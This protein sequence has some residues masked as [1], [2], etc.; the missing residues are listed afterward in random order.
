[1]L[2]G[3]EVPGQPSILSPSNPAYSLFLLLM[4]IHLRRV[5]DPPALADGRRILVDR[6][7]PRGLK[8]EAATLDRW[9]RE[10]APS[11]A[12]RREFGHDH[13]RWDEFRARYFAELDANPKPV[14]RLAA[15]AR[16]GTVTLLFAARDVERNNAVALRE[17]LE[18]RTR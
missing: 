5:Y 17:Y 15:E 10:L 1:M 4:P 14:R 18:A 11:E 16:Q 12:L 7:W 6:L 9:D 2:Q 3:I 13:S 8:K